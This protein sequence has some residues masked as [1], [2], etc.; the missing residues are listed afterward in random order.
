MSWCQRMDS[1]GF[2]LSSQLGSTTFLEIS[3]PAWLQVK[4][5]LRRHYHEIQKVKVKQQPY[6]EL[7]NK[8]RQYCSSHIVMDIWARLCAGGSNCAHSSPS[9]CW[10]FSVLP[11]NTGAD[12][13]QLHGQAH[14]TYYRLSTSSELQVW[15]Q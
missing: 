2:L 12:R 13:V 3:L 7:Y 11:S 14:H 8:V 1:D 6:S 10:I 4:D 5:G 9:S 15:K